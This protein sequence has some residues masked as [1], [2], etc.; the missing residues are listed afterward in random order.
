ML[1]KF[2][3]IPQLAAVMLTGLLCGFFLAYALDVAPALQRL[4][5]ASYI[6]V[7]QQLNQTISN[8]GFAVL[9]FGA[10][11]FPFLSAALAAWQSRRRMAMYWLLVALLHFIGVY[12]VSV[13][14]SIPLHQE[15]LVWDPKAPHP[16]WQT[17]RDGWVDSNWIRTLVE[18]VC[19]LASLALVIMREQLA[20]SPRYMMRKLQ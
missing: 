12:W 16:D 2:L 9:F 8:P 6:Q 15:M 7:Q 14:S 18:L 17:L 4:D 5:A 10:T 3:L 20:A 13:V 1:P 11:L 19:F